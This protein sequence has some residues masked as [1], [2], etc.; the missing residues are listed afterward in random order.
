MLTSAS[1]NAGVTAPRNLPRHAPAKGRGTTLWAGLLLSVAIITSAEAAPASA[2]M[3]PIRPVELLRDG[4]PAETV[5]QQPATAAAQNTVRGVH[6]STEDEMPAL[7]TELVKAGVIEAAAVENLKVPRPCSLPQ[8]VRL[9]GIRLAD[10]NLVRLRP[11]ATM[12]CEM[13]VAILDWTREDLAPA[14]EQLGA[15]LEM[16]KVASSYA[17]RGR[18]RKKGAR[19]SEH[20][21]GNAMDVSGFELS[22]GRTFT[23]KAGLPAP[24]ALAMKQSA[25]ERFATVLGPGSDGYH[26]DHIHVDLA[27]RRKSY[28]LCRWKLRNRTPVLAR[29]TAQAAPVPLPAPKPLMP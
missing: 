5:M 3:P 25:C 9:D 2:P 12:S 8:P 26:E 16:L 22:D 29:Q 24:L 15:R 21:F 7:C 10:G 14:V 4:A 19:I 11:G 13:V 27:K 28:K 17:C 23:I 1:A 6:V 20:G 18:N